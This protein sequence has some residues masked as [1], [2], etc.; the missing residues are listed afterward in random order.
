MSTV[1]DTGTRSR[2]WPVALTAGLL[3]V[4]V[5]LNLMQAVWIAERVHRA[6]HNGTVAGA[7][8]VW[9]QTAVFCVWYV[10]TAWG[11]LRSK[12][13]GWISALIVFGL[14]SI[15]GL[16]SLLSGVVG[17]LFNLV[18]GPASIY[19]LL[20]PDTRREVGAG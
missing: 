10:V 15:G 18:L 12:R 5:P 17:G 16:V 13:W 3:L 4:A 8:A 2:P 20:R 7:G 1:A 11:L 19:L 6:A 9:T 14:A